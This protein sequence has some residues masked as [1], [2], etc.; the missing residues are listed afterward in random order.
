MS[1]PVFLITA[2]SSGFGRAIALEAL[3]RGHSVIAT[4]RDAS[5]LTDLQSRGASVLSLDVTS[6]ESVLSAKLAEAAA[7]HGGRITHVVNAAGYIF[8]GAIEEASQEEVQ[9]HYA[10]NVFGVANMAR[11]SAPYLRQAAADKGYGGRVV[12]ASFGSLGS[13]RSD[14]AVA[15]Y[16]ST[17]AAVSSLMVGL[18]GELKPFGID[19]CCVEPGYTRTEFLSLTP[20]GKERRVV[21]KRNLKVYENGPVAD[22]K[23]KL[24]VYN[25]NQPGD[26]NKCAKLI[27]DVFTG[28]GVGEGREIPARLPL[29]SDTLEVVRANIERSLTMIREWEDVAK[30]A[31]YD[32]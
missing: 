5:T 29:G 25:G 30:L 19:V 8:A 18:V 26:V 3:K 10:T 6:S 9:S 16:C 15:H 21:A 31:D 2:T 13:Y 27:V 12:Y 17:K 28:V 24:D 1:N 4:A 11:A 23:G 20:G 7:I 32:A 22:I 14:P